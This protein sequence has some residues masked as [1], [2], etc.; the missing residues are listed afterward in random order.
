MQE[1]IAGAQVVGRVGAVLR[2]V[3]AAA[4]S[5]SSTSQ[6]AAAASLTR[7]TTHRLLT[8]LMSEGYLDRDRASGQW[9]LGPELYLMGTIAAQRYDVTGRAREIVAELADQT[10]ESAFFSARRQDESVCLLRVEGSFPIRSF[11]LHEGVR[12]PLGVASAGLA[13]L[14]HLPDREVDEYVR[15][16]DLVARWG[17]AH[18]PSELRTRIQQTRERG[19]AVNPGLIV[20][21]SWGMGAAVFSAT[22]RPDWALSITG[23]E[24]RFQPARQPELGRLLLDLAHTLTRKLTGL[25]T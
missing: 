14:S 15:R 19:Y 24:S 10:G 7:S 20:E 17:P 25:P 21:G 2:A 12:F 22:G 13:M 11:V 1:P 3:A 9:F 18:G 16:R 6:V 23:V 5:G 4:P 8:S